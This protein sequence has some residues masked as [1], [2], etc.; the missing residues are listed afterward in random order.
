MNKTRRFVFQKKK[1]KRKQT[2]ESNM[3][4]WTV[5]KS[6]EA[7]T[8]GSRRNICLWFGAPDIHT[9][10]GAAWALA[11]DRLWIITTNGQTSGVKKNPQIT[12]SG[13]I[14]ISSIFNT[15]YYSFLTLLIYIFLLRISKVYWKDELEMRLCFFIRSLKT[16]QATF[17]RAFLHRLDG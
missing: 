13:Q 1:R 8:T 15:I 11:Q 3:K 14:S 10:F 7:L 9:N 17:V 6:S 4:C 2:Q 16:F 5:M 12:T